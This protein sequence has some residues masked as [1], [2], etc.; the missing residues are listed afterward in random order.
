MKENNRDRKEGLL[1]Y[2]YSKVT[3]LF[4]MPKAD[5]LE[6]MKLYYHKYPVPDNANALI[7]G[8]AKSTVYED[9]VPAR[10][11]E[12]AFRVFIRDVVTLEYPHPVYMYHYKGDYQILEILVGTRE[13][14]KQV[15]LGDFYVSEG[16]FMIAFKEDSSLMSILVEEL[17]KHH[18]VPVATAIEELV[19]KMLKECVPQHQILKK[20]FRE[21]WYGLVITES[22]GQWLALPV[23]PFCWC[24]PG[25]FVLR[26]KYGV[27]RPAGPVHF[28][29]QQQNNLYWVSA[30]E[31]KNMVKLLRGDRRV[32]SWR[33][34]LKDEFRYLPESLQHEVAKAIAVFGGDRWDIILESLSKF[35]STDAEVLI[36]ALY[37]K[38][39]VEEF[40]S[41]TN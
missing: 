24:S 33:H 41:E 3:A 18:G 6:P 12:E 9:G 17:I 32:G 37:L 14:F 19:G 39:L 30:R 8:F 26:C 23:E 11:N 16:V 28:E 13:K 22:D 4:D 1:K 27:L 5:E 10:I 25:R 34:F 20:A 15:F 2:D 36:S 29:V 35:R 21:R 7:V 31:I 40:S 38:K